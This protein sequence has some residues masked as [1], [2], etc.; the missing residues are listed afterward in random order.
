MRDGD[1]ETA[2]MPDLTRVPDQ[3][4]GAKVDGLLDLVDP[5]RL[6]G[7]EGVA[8]EDVAGLVGKALESRRVEPREV[9]AIPVELVVDF[10]GERTHHPGTRRR[11]AYEPL[12]DIEVAP[13]RLAGI[14]YG[15][16]TEPFPALGV[17]QDAEVVPMPVEVCHEVVDGQHLLDILANFE[18]V[19]GAGPDI[20]TMQ[21]EIGRPLRGAQERVGR[22]ELGEL[23]G[24]GLAAR[25]PLHK[26]AVFEA[27]GYEVS[28]IEQA[29]AQHAGDLLVER[30]LEPIGWPA[31]FDEHPAAAFDRPALR[32][33]AVQGRIGRGREDIRIAL[34]LFDERGY[35]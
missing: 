19:G 25:R 8:E 1:G 26:S 20:E 6:V 5:A 35:R 15:G 14:E 11:V 29:R 30:F 4:H 22:D 24:H 33:V 28:V 7:D 31:G 23:V 2:F 18:S 21:A 10:A 16:G 27:V 17:N 9:A 13:K 3:H 12:R 34:D 32:E